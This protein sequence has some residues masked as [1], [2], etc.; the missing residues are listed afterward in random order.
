M[1]LSVLPIKAGNTL[2]MDNSEHIAS[3]LSC[4]QVQKLLM[5]Q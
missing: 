2:I 5:L 1:L 4:L 3:E